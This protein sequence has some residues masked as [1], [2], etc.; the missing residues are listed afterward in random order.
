MGSGQNRHVV[1][2]IPHHQ[3]PPSLPLPSLYLIE[4]VLGTHT[5][6][7]LIRP[8]AQTLGYGRHGSGAVAR[9]HLDLHAHGRQAAHHLQGISA[10]GFA[11]FKAGHP[12]RFIPQMHTRVH[13]FLEWGPWLVA[14]L[15]LPERP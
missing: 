13:G 4:F 5:A 10:Q 3:H 14:P 15:G 7:N 8:Q 6:A 1:E 11:D 9:Q 2:T 12:T